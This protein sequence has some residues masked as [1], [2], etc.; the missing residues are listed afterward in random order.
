MG[1][2]YWMIYKLEEQKQPINMRLIVLTAHRLFG[3]SNGVDVVEDYPSL[4]L[5]CHT[6]DDALVVEKWI[7]EDGLKR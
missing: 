7:S 3:K 6:K 5:K 4:L 2:N 1:V